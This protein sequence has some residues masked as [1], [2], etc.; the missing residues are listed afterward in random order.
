MP[1]AHGLRRHVGLREA[2]A[3]QGGE[4][5]GV[6]GRSRED[7]AADIRRELRPLLEQEGVVGLDA[8]SVAGEGSGEAG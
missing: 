4:R 3:L 8:A 2:E 7:E 1:A 5:L 6:V